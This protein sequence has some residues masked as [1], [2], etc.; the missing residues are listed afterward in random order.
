MKVV[1]FS[2]L[3]IF[4]SLCQLFINLCE[5]LAPAVL[6]TILMGDLYC[7]LMKST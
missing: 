3:E 5:M 1:I 4:N 2:S 6:G 7:R